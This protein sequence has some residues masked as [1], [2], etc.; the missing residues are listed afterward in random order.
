MR[1]ILLIACLLLVGTQAITVG[2]CQKFS[3]DGQSCQKCVDHFHLY[4]GNCFVDILGCQ[5]YTFGNICH[6]CENGYILVN[7]LCCDHNC[8][9]K[10]FKRHESTK[11]TKTI[12][13][14]FKIFNRIIP[15][16][17]QHYIKNTVHNLVEIEEHGYIH[18]IR[19]V[20]LYEFPNGRFK[21]RRAVVDV[22]RETEQI[23]MVDWTQIQ[24][25]SELMDFHKD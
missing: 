1:E 20:I 5:S 16:V 10:L 13:Q 18:V 9:A 7:N 25:V 4:E 15:F 2:S 12:S 21:M 19:Y 17:N 14:N 11:V 22:L 8:L 24:S 6:S 3:L 23:V